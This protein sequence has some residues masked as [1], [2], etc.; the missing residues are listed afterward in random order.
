MP[1]TPETAEVM[2]S[3]AARSVVELFQLNQ[4]ASRNLEGLTRSMTVGAQSA[5]LIR[6]QIADYSAKVFQSRVSQAQALASARTLQDVVQLQT[7]YVQQSIAQFT[8]AFTQMS[9]TYTALTKESVAPIA[10]RMSAITPSWMKA[11]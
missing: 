6:S 7:S 4:L 10:E 8:S 3:T 1:K 2:E 5:E 9:S 11:A